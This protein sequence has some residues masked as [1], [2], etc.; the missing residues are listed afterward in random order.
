MSLSNHT[1]VNPTSFF[2]MGIP[3]LES[4][5][6][7][8]AFPFCS[9]YLLAV[10]GNVTVLL[11]VATEASL[12][13]PMFLFLSMLATLDLLLCSATVPK[14]LAIFWFD[15]SWISL[16]A[17]AAQMFFIHGFSAVESGVLLAMALDR[18]GAICQPLHYATILTRANVAKMGAA[19]FLRGLGLMT[20]LTCLV[21]SLPYCSQVIRHSYCEHMAVVKLACGDTTPNNIY[22]LTAATLVV[23]MDA[24]GI[25]VSYVL[26][27]RVVLGLPSREAR[28]KAF[29]TCGS[30]LCVILIFYMPALFSFYTQRFGRRVPSHVHILLADLYLLVPPMLNPIIYGMKTKQLRDRVAWSIH[31]SLVLAPWGLPQH[32]PPPAIH[33]PFPS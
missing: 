23:G 6:F 1:H 21:Q 31:R 17:C 24:L 10:L 7:W 27:L 12:Q 19:A 22:G 13:Q 11:V 28:T 25:A 16:G 2:L 18:H 8:L 20:P 4:A 3:G 32:P 14:I 30:H 26:I 15:A 33:G 5:H 9:M 29:S